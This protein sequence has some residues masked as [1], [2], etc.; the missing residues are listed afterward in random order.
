MLVLALD[1]ASPTPGVALADSENVFEEALP[2][3]R[4]S[5]ESLLPAVARLFASAGRSLSEC[6]RIAVCAGPGS[7]TGLRI[8][9]ASAW[10]PGRTP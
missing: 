9:M 10:G 1:A 4:R 7:F 3:D 6:E 8:A 5:S 2:S